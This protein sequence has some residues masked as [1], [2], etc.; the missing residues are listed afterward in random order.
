MDAHAGAVGAPRDGLALHVLAAQ[1]LLTTEEALAHVRHLPLDVRLALGMPH[2]RRVDDEAAVPRVLVEHAAED[3]VVAVGLRDRRPQI[4]EDDAARH[5]A[6]EVPGILQALDQIRQLLAVRHVH[7]LVAAVHQR[8]HQRVQQAP[9]L[10]E[11][12]QTQPAEVDLGHLTRRALGY[13]HRQAIAG[14]KAA[15]LDREAVQGAV[16]H[17]HAATLQQ[18]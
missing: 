7:V 11:G 4:V 12:H 16:R 15:V 18:V 3:R 10:A 6:E 8:H 1:P 13:A 2:H 17:V 14:A 5:P 9:P